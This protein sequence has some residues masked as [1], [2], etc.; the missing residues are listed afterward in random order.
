VLAGRG[1]GDGGTRKS[2]AGTGRLVWERPP[3]VSRR[4]YVPNDRLVAATLRNRGFGEV[5]VDAAA[6]VKLVDR[7]GRPVKHVITFGGR[8]KALIGPGEAVPVRMAFRILA[9]K[10]GPY[11]LELPGGG[12]LTVPDR[13]GTITG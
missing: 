13:G 9:L 12:T 6:N 2:P 8:T 10:R 5:R 4:R 1:D 3:R 7:A 11:R